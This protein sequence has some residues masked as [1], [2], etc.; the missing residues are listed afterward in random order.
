MAKEKRTPASKQCEDAM[1]LKYEG[2]KYENIAKQIKVPAGTIRN[3]FMKDGL[4]YDAYENFV[5]E[6]NLETRKKM[7]AGLHQAGETAIK[8][9]AALM[10]SKSDVVKLGAI[11]EINDR[12]L[13]KP[14]QPIVMPEKPDDPDDDGMSYEER[15]A[16]F[17]QTYGKTPADNKTPRK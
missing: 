15:L 8:M 9:L 11:R 4:L 5:R 16:L 6:I 2:M 10:G 12:I 17:E 13:G 1:R 14:V 7:S 3:W